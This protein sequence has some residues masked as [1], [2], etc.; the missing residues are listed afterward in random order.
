[1][2]L[3]PLTGPALGPGRHDGLAGLSRKM[4]IRMNPQDF[5]REN[6]AVS[7]LPDRTPVEKRRIESMRRQE[8]AASS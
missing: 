3:S 5:Q 1:M 2:L 8:A 6:R 4:G 7:A